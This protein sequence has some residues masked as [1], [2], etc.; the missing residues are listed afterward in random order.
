M[1]PTYDYEY[2]LRRWQW[3]IGCIGGRVYLEELIDTAKRRNA[4]YSTEVYCKEFYSKEFFSNEFYSKEFYSKE[5][6]SK[7]FY[8]KE[9]YSK[10]FYPKEFLF[11]VKGHGRVP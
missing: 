6:Y 2:C 4:T 5:F 11:H 1:K 8:S 3:V 7:W 10:E 9:F